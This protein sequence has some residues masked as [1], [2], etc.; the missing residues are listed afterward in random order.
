MK[1]P[2]PHATEPFDV[3][4]LRPTRGKQGHRLGS[5]SNSP[6]TTSEI[7]R[8]P[9]R[10]EQ[11][12]KHSNWQKAAIP[13]PTFGKNRGR[14]PCKKSVPPT[15]RARHRYETLPTRMCLVPIGYRLS[16]LAGSA[17][18]KATER[19]FQWRLRVGSV[20][21]CTLRT[22]RSQEPGKRRPQ[23]AKRLILPPQSCRKIL[24]SG[25][26]NAPVRN[27]WTCFSLVRLRKRQKACYHS[28]ICNGMYPSR[29]SADSDPRCH[30]VGLVAQHVAMQHPRSRIV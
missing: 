22:A 8:Q 6:W 10:T 9:H 23:T 18:Q 7:P 30:T 5:R 27:R 24:V 12:S 11:E 25:S 13:I 1:R 3:L 28:E 17:E 15:S 16:G 14:I 21:R 4:R 29:P 20:A 19:P 26:M 2:R